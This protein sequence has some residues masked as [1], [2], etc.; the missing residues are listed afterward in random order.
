MRRLEPKML[1]FCKSVSCTDLKG[2]ECSLDECKY[3]DKAAA[4]EQL[5]KGLQEVKH[6]GNS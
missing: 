6:G 4:V 1:R 2:L 3:S 5:H